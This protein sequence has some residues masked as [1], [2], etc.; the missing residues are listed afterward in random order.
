MAVAAGTAALFVALVGDPATLP[1]RMGC[2][3]VMVLA[4]V[5]EGMSIGV[6][7]WGVLRRIFPTLTA[8]AWLIPTISVA[9]GGWFVGMLPQIFFGGDEGAEMT[10][11]PSPQMVMIF[12]TVFGGIAGVVFGA[13]QWLVLRRH[14]ERATIWIW[15]NGFGWALAMAVSYLGASLPTAEWTLGAV[16]L[17]GA[18]TGIVAGLT[19]GAVTGAGLLQLLRGRP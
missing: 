13:A 4:G 3:A 12:A 16:V 17:T 10:P 7:Q 11:E 6:F 15:T 1:S 8:R 14:I 2:L 19:I 5:L 18:L 9:A